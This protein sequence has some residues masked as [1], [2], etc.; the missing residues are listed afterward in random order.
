MD[1]E[2]LD[3]LLDYAS[4]ALVNPSDLGTNVTGQ[5]LDPGGTF[6]LSTLVIFL[7]A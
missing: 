5:E 2:Q 1:E 3:A 6:G 7:S 4:T